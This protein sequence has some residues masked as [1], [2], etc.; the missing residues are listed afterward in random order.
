MEF[1]QDDLDNMNKE[2]ESW[3]MEYRKAQSKRDEQ[4]RET[5]ETLQPLYD[6][7]AELEE[8]IKETQMKVVNKKAQINKND[9]VIKDLL[10]NVIQK[11]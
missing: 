5:E 3:K 11:V 7:L 10:E 8:T 1:V 6:K 9:R 2:L 4:V